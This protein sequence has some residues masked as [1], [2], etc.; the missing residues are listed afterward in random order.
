M[1]SYIRT[2]DHLTVVFENGESVTVY[3]SN[4]KYSDIIA[5]LVA[6]DDDKIRALASPAKVVEE[7]VTIV[8]KRDNVD[9][10]LR[11]GV[12][13]YKG[14][15]LHNTLTDRIVQMSVE[16]FDIKPMINFLSNLQQNPSY[17]AVTELYSFLEKGNLP[18]TEDGYFL[19]YKKVRDDYKDCHSGTFDNSVGQ[20]VTMPRNK[21]NEDPKQTCSSGLHFCSRDYLS[22]FGGVR[23]MILKINP[24]DVVAIPADYNDT[25]GR[26][27]RYEVIG[28][29]G[30][31]EKLEG[32]FRPS[33]TY[34]EPPSDFDDEDDDYDDG[35]DFFDS[36]DYDDGDDFF[37]SDDLD[38]D[39]VSAV[40]VLLEE[41]KDGNIVL[42][43]GAIVDTVPKIEAFYLE[44]EKHTVVEIFNT[45]EEAAEWAAVEKSA[46]KRVLK[47]DRQ[48]T[49]G[50]G[51]R[52][53]TND[54]PHPDF[55]AAQRDN[56][57]L[58]GG[59]SHS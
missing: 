45:I 51:W 57:S 46:I 29:L 2:N 1:T 47:G 54:T 49:G 55:L 28:E 53:P 6:K 36:D 22:N 40:D 37:D 17:R 35:D 13:Y 7:K 48:S 26:T 34:V 44:D 12:V 39:D 56:G 43:P 27:C 33:N 19:A 16:G 41:D 32:A 30:A 25:K 23:V 3:P 18:I 5:A 20:V 24:A 11:D 58:Y 14:E 42:A 8:A 15:G 31:D 9:V 59:K 52:F 21:V 10:E 50:Y 38:E 4:P